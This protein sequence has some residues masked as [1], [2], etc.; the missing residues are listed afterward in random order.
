MKRLYTLTMFSIVLAACIFFFK[1]RSA[2][3]ITTGNGLVI[4]KEWLV[5]NKDPRTPKADIRPADQTFLTYPEWFL[6]F[7]PEEQA[8]YFNHST[9]TTFPYIS[10]VRQFWE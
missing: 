9:A 1:D 8:K 7:S 3:T 10:H 4:P 6:V 5:I 2:S